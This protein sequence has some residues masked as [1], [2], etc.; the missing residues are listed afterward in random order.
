MSPVGIFVSA[1]GCHCFNFISSRTTVHV[2]RLGNA[3]RDRSVFMAG[4]DR[5]YT[6][7]DKD[8]FEL[9][10]CGTKRDF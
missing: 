4:R 2:L 7:L 10:E 6:I 3:V 1:T 8:L 5:K 9:S